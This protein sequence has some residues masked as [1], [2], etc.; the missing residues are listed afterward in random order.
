MKSS[1]R[2]GGWMPTVNDLVGLEGRWSLPTTTTRHLCDSEDQAGVVS[3]KLN[4][5][6]SCEGGLWS[7]SPPNF[8][9]PPDS[10]FMLNY[11]LGP[12]LIQSSLKA[13]KKKEEVW[14]KDPKHTHTHTRNDTHKSAHN[15][16]RTM[17]FRVTAAQ[18]PV[19]WKGSL[20]G[21]TLQR[22]TLK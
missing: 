19:C 15:K 22:Q 3:E 2:S 17:L 8:P 4:W 14:W 11:P 7:P 10:V 18:K 12:T 21:L 20:T 13:L 1:S 16:R 6:A 5:A 9:S